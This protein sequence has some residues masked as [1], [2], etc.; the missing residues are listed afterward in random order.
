MSIDDIGNDELCDLWEDASRDVI[1]YGRL[2][3]A[4]MDQK[5]TH[6][7]VIVNTNPN[8]YDM[9]LYPDKI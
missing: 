7:E 6:P 3:I 2:V 8:Q 4:R 1:K 5:R 9:F